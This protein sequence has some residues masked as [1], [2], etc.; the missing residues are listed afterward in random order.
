M[1]LQGGLADEAIG[2]MLLPFGTTGPGIA[3]SELSGGSWAMTPQ[4]VSISADAM[5]FAWINVFAKR[6]GAHCNSA[7]AHAFCVAGRL[8]WKVGFG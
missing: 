3:G 6:F 5:L 4:A 2:T 8:E 7:V 1:V